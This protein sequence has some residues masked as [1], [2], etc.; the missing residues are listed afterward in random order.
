MIESGQEQDQDN[1][2]FLSNTL[3]HQSGRSDPPLTTTYR[4]GSILDA[5][6]PVAQLGER[7]NRTVEAKGSNP[8]RSIAPYN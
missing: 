1:L 6:G 7:Y 3:F 4:W 8:F 5:S 2:V